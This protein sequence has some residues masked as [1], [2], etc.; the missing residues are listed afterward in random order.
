MF[1]LIGRLV[2]GIKTYRKV[3]QVVKDVDTMT[4][5]VKS[6]SESMIEKRAWQVVAQLKNKYKGINFP[7]EILQKLIEIGIKF[8]NG[9]KAPT[10][11]RDLCYMI[12]KYLFEEAKDV[13]YYIEKVFKKR[14]R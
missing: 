11:K 14:K 5:L 2:T 10:E 9:H 3:K 4:N 6:Y 7:E 1:K 8:A 13:L 12:V